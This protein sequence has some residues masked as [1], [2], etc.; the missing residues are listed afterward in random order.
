MRIK[1][2]LISTF[3]DCALPIENS[4]RTVQFDRSPEC[5]QSFNDPKK[6][7]ITAIVLT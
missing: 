7:S 3:A 4:L 1:K 2:R 6:K 5:Q